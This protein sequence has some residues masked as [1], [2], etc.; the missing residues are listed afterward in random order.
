MNISDSIAHFLHQVRSHLNRALLMRGLFLALSACASACILWALSWRIFGYAAPHLGYLV[1]AGMTLIIGLMIY[2]MK[3][4]KLQ[5]AA[6]RADE[7]F[8]LKDALTSYLDFQQRPDTTCEVY[9]L[10]EKTVERSIARHQPTTIVSRV[11]HQRKWLSAALSI[12]AIILALLPHSPAV[13]DRIAQ[14]QLML[15][16]STQVR[17]EMEE[18]VEEMIAA[19]D[20]Q[21]KELLKPEQL[22]QWVKD[23]EGTK[24]QREAMK[25][26]AKFEQKISEAMKGLEA[27]KDEEILKLAAA[28]LGASQ[29]AEAK[30]LGKK[31]ENK[32][33]ANA[34]Q[35]LSEIKPAKPKELKKLSSEEMKKLQERAAKMK[36]MS[37]RMANG[38]RKRDFGN[39]GKNGKNLK[40]TDG[41]EAGEAKEM[42]QLLQDL[43]DAAA[44]ADKQ[45]AEMEEGDIGEM[46]EGA[47]DKLDKDLEKL[48]MR[49]GK[50]DAKQK[51]RARMKALGKCAGQSQKFC[52]GQSQLLGLAQM[53]AQQPGGLKPGTGHLDNKRKGED[54]RTDNENLTQLKGQQ[55]EGPSRSSVEQADSGEGISGRASTDKNRDFRKQTESLV[56][57]DDVPEELK[58]GIREYFNRVHEIETP[59]P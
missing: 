25:Q 42:D 36:E 2:R 28:E 1:I 32:D 5:D 37:N 40:A 11:P 10:Q 35:Q 29:M 31:L 3:L 16:R 17:E 27:R 47:M 51:A 58:Q 45:L 14:Q 49:L 20:E 33:F 53:Q 9:Q 59:E 21:E 54:E 44:D 26:L 24:D 8:Q 18:I 52:N 19:M 41:K 46:A 38:A 13:K 50:L 30:Q 34:K 39:Q 22:R 43:E 55:G 48:G 6:V 15:D 12:I 4:H 7:H 23:L 57:R 56:Q